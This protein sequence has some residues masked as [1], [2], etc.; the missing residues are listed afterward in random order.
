MYQTEE[1][2]QHRN[3]DIT[4]TLLSTFLCDSDDKNLDNDGRSDEAFMRSITAFPGKHTNDYPPKR[5]KLSNGS[6]MESTAKDVLKNRE[7]KVTNEELR[8]RIA[9]LHKKIKRMTFHIMELNDQK[10]QCLQQLNAV[11]KE[12]QDLMIQV[13][14]HKKRL[15]MIMEKLD[16]F[17]K[18]RPELSS[19]NAVM[20]KESDDNSAIRT[21]LLLKDRNS[22]TLSVTA[23]SVSA[24]S[25][26]AKKRIGVGPRCIV[27]NQQTENCIKPWLTCTRC[28]QRVNLYCSWMIRDP[29]CSIFTEREFICILCKM[30][31]IMEHPKYDRKQKKYSKYPENYR[32]ELMLF[33]EKT[34]EYLMRW[35]RNDDTPQPPQNIFCDEDFTV[36]RMLRYCWRKRNDLNKQQQRDAAKMQQLYGN[37]NETKLHSLKGHQVSISKE[38]IDR[39]QHLS[40]LPKHIHSSLR[41]RGN[42]NGHSSGIRPIIN[43]HCYPLNGAYSGITTM[44]GIF[45]A[46]ELQWI[47]RCAVEK[48][49]VTPESDIVQQHPEAFDFKQ[50]NRTDRV[51]V[52]IEY[53]YT[54]G[55]VQAPQE[56][57]QEL[58]DGV[59]KISHRK[60]KH[61]RYK[62]PGG[63]MNDDLDDAEERKQNLLF[64]TSLKMASL[65][66]AQFV[67]K[68]IQTVIVESGLYKKE[69]FQPDQVQINRY[70][71]HSGIETH[72][73]EISWFDFPIIT[74]RLERESALH[75]GVRQRKER[76]PSLRIKLNV[77]TTLIM[78]SWAAMKYRHCVRGKEHQRGY[79]TALIIR[80]IKTSAV[81]KCPRYIK[82]RYLKTNDV[83]EQTKGR[84]RVNQ[85]NVALKLE[86]E[87]ESSLSS[88]F[89]Y[90]L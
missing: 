39:I 27:C 73:D 74:L 7:M 87:N 49:N 10:S 46:D 72:F 60:L 77:G 29:D 14:D 18:T 63:A 78:E 37:H 21:S 50:T 26:C 9:E 58:P 81:S 84:K 56:I 55:D 11:R 54:Y 44:D 68:R 12:N 6:R 3:E 1:L 25:L 75:F 19:I 53:G 89:D 45:T 2:H 33:V 35:E 32:L 64:R 38:Q 13:H 22:K 43:K 16:A 88:T 31:D 17:E 65:E 83:D 86:S 62:T 30:Q 15:K 40:P 69:E 59:P 4:Q 51:K 66:C 85:L 8:Q 82:N 36:K 67:I 70:G 24:N 23:E 20:K 80:K 90:N 5:R 41:L 71:K 79:S 28:H 48:A 34:K 42:R 52:Y 61:R 76:N 47:T 57:P